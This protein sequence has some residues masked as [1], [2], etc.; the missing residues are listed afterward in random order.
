ML[1][2]IIANQ[3][4]VNIYIIAKN[5]LNRF[6]FLVRTAVRTPLNSPSILEGVAAGRGSNMK[7]QNTLWKK[8][9]NNGI[10]I[11]GHNVWNL[12]SNKNLS[13]YAHK[14]GESGTKDGLTANLSY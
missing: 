11:E 6:L 4:Q 7:Y 12:S 8:A 10:R 9:A 13:A 2:H 1:I 3:L 14:Y 5:M